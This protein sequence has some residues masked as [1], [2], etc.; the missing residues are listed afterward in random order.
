MGAP[1]VGKLP[2]CGICKKR[3]S[4]EACP[5]DK[6]KRRVAR[7]AAKLAANLAEQFARCPAPIQLD[8]QAADP[9]PV[10]TSSNKCSVCHEKSIMPSGICINHGCQS[11]WVCKCGY[12]NPR[13]LGGMDLTALDDCCCQRCGQAYN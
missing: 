5:P 12:A 10:S 8:P 2:K 9:L 7:R 4:G 3:Y 6:C 1:V 13:T 11:N